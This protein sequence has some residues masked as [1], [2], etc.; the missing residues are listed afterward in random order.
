MTISIEYILT[1][2]ALKGFGPKKI[3]QV[4]DALDHSRMQSILLEDLYGILEDLRNEGR[5]KGLSEFPDFYD[6]EE[7]NK[8]ARRIISRSESLGI[9]MISRFDA[10]FPRNLLQTV[11]EQGRPDVPLLL[12]YKGDLS[13]ASR[14]AIAIIGTR[15]PSAHGVKAGE[16]FGEYFGNQGFNIVSGLALG[17]DSA[18]HRGAMR[19]SCGVTTAFLAHGLDTIYPPENKALADEIVA[20]GGLLMTEYPVGEHVNRNYLVSRD[21][22]QAALA[23]ATL[24]IQTGI[25]GGT[26]HA[27]NA[28]LA[29]GK[30]VYAV[31][32]KVPIPERKDEGNRWLIDG[33]KAL[34]LQSGNRDEVV[35]TVLG[36]S[37]LSPEPVP[38]KKD[39]DTGHEAEF[40]QGSLF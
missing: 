4:A 30:T 32:Y 34:P 26:M 8:K 38:E 31:D 29:A 17:C 21:R 19:S 28:T 1:L 7:A 13:A 35:C 12:F 10:E 40:I 3:E 25:K 23:D 36:A 9:K 15:E 33:G 39:E 5:L 18:G 2:K 27:V 20:K 37:G 22:L 24:V 16:V 6:L 11:N 14:P